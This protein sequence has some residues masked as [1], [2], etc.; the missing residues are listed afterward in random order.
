MNFNFFYQEEF[1]ETGSWRNTKIWLVSAI[2]LFCFLKPDP[3]KRDPFEIIIENSE[4]CLGWDSILKRDAFTLIFIVLYKLEN[5]IKRMFIIWKKKSQTFSKFIDFL[6]QGWWEYV[7]LKQTGSLALKISS[8]V[9][10]W[11]FLA[12]LTLFEK[13][14]LLC[15]VRICVREPS[16]H[17]PL[18]PSV[19]FPL[20][21]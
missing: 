13:I 16:W 2:N 20:K 14:I 5:K 17:F 8:I 11:V 3:Q 15:Q 6:R 4:F 18:K 7:V 21:Y 9:N 19:N 12:I 1:A 10:S